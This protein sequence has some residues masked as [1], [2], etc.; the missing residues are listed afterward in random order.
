[1]WPV[2]AKKKPPGE[3]KP[4]QTPQKELRRQC[5]RLSPVI[6]DYLL[7]KIYQDLLPKQ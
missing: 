4:L 1:M 6:W 7:Q 5:H 2:A 3:A